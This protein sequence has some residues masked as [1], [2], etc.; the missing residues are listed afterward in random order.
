MPPKPAESIFSAVRT[1]ETPVKT[2]RPKSRSEQEQNRIIRE[3]EIYDSTK[4]AA[5]FNQIGKGP[6]D[7]RCLRRPGRTYIHS[8]LDLA[9]D[10]YFFPVYLRRRTFIIYSS[11]DICSAKI[12]NRRSPTINIG[13]CG[14]KRQKKIVAH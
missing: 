5:K 2:T 14:G 8:L 4:L 11:V 1:P 7:R 6:L 13:T 3:K 9:S 10:I 12:K